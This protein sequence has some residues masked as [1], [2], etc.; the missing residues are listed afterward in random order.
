[1]DII[2]L[3]DLLDESN[4]ICDESVGI[5]LEDAC[6][7]Y[8]DNHDLS[9]MFELSMES[10]DVTFEGY[11]KYFK[12]VKFSHNF[13]DTIEDSVKR[14][15]EAGGEK[16]VKTLIPILK[17]D[18]FETIKSKSELKDLDDEYRKEHPI[19]NGLL[20]HPEDRSLT[21][22]NGILSIVLSSIGIVTSDFNSEPVPVGGTVVIVQNYSKW[23]NRLTKEK[24]DKRGG[25]PLGCYAVFWNPEKKTF[26][27][28]CIARQK[29]IDFGGKDTGA[30]IK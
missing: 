18:G 7:E 11:G 4:D 26:K 16:L 22:T 15:K 1:M 17:K 19:R 28:I 20:G 2:S 12:P 29:F 27:I 13:D 14:L 24:H 21:A 6:I 10:T 8:A 25:K 5:Q 3:N 23:W 30:V 9:E